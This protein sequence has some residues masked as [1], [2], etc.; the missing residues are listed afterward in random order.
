MFMLLLLVMTCAFVAQRVF[1]QKLRLTFSCCR[2]CCRFADWRWQL[3]AGVH[4]LCGG[5]GRGHKG[6][7]SRQQIGTTGADA[8]SGGVMRL[9][10]CTVFSAQ[11]WAR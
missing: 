5:P 3:W 11:N 4:G 8:D 7:A 9:L 2:C 1:T 6:G 10:C